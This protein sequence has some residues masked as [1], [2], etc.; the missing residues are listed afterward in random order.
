MSVP[1][2]VRF[3]ESKCPRRKRESGCCWC[4]SKVRSDQSC[5]FTARPVVERALIRIKST[6]LK[7]YL[8]IYF[9]F[10]IREK[11]NKKKKEHHHLGGMMIRVVVRVSSHHN[12]LL[13]LLLSMGLLLSLSQ[14]VCGGVSSCRRN[15]VTSSPFRKA[16]LRRYRSLQKTLNISN[17][18]LLGE[19]ANARE[20]YLL[21]QKAAP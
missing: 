11:K 14:L 20:N 15:R 18:K 9:Q 4:C 2:I 5:S 3:R 6:T 1:R 8:D 19:N 21:P 13:V 17:P 12:Y 10:D 16:P 7:R